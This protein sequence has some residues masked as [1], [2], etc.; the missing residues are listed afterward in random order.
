MINNFARIITADS[1]TDPT[2]LT[3]GRVCEA[4]AGGGATEGVVGAGDTEVDTEA[5]TTAGSVVVVEDVEITMTE[6]IIEVVDPCLIEAGTEIL[7]LNIETTERVTTE[8]RR[9]ERLERLERQSPTGRRIQFPLLQIVTTMEHLLDLW[10]TGNLSPKSLETVRLLPV[11]SLKDSLV[12]GRGR[13][14]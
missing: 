11:P 3:T 5:G 7:L 8:I 1:G 2:V 13:R 14:R 12:R 6:D 4:G 9:I 10:Q